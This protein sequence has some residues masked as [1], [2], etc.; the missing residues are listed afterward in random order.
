[1]A[2]EYNFS[3]TYPVLIAWI[4]LCFL[5]DVPKYVFMVDFLYL[6]QGEDDLTWLV[7]DYNDQGWGYFRW[8]WHYSRLGGWWY[9]NPSHL[10]H[11]CSGQ[12]YDIAQ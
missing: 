4:H 1:M 3:F 11:A 12:W 10:F 6:L 7:P 2:L 9:R 8:G 5:F